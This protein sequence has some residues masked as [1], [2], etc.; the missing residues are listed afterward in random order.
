[1][2]NL[3]RLKLGFN[4]HKGEQ[5]GDMLV[6][7]EH[8]LNL[9]T[10][11]ASIGAAPD[12]E[13]CD[14]TA[15]ESALKAA[16]RKHPC[17]RSFE[18]VKMV[19]RV[20]EV[21]RLKELAFRSQPKPRISTLSNIVDSN[22][23]PLEV[24]LVDA[25]TKSPS[26][27]PQELRIEVVA[28]KG[29]YGMSYQLTG[30]SFDIAIARESN[31]GPEL[32]GDVR[33]TMRDGRATVGELQFTQG[34]S[35]WGTR[36]FAI[37]VRVVPGSYN[38]ARILEAM[39]KAFLVEEHPDVRMSKYPPALD[40]PVW[41]LQMIVKGGEFHKKLVHNNINTVQ[42]FLRMLTLMPDELRAIVGDMRDN[43]WEATISHA[44]TCSL[45]DKAYVYSTAQGTIYLNSVFDAVRV[46]TNGIEWPHAQLQL[47]R[48]QK[49]IVQQLTLEAYQHRHSLQE[50][51]A[52]MVHIDDPL[53]G[54]KYLKSQQI[55]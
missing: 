31:G 10:I 22:D 18:Q 14:R 17:H 42:D 44:K 54:S 24:I 29:A 3:R 11:A 9:E 1:M 8:L 19:D 39:T 23:N 36:Q 45:G 47:N 7:I 6:G 15:A 53:Q 55:F 26:V 33:L 48:D 27:L 5:Y 46:K 32:I 40:D 16:V 28:L 37:G 43:M 2:P 51:D 34:N 50:I 25:E 21:D 38:G 20:D 12:A 35:F 4:A 30:D 13:E 41:R 52:A 49:T